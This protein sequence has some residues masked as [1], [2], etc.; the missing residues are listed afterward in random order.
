MKQITIP[1]VVA[2]VIIASL[3]CGVGK[4]Q[5]EPQPAPDTVEQKSIEQKSI[6]QKTE[7]Q[8]VPKVEI[9]VQYSHLNFFDRPLTLFDYPKRS[10]TLGGRIT[11]NLT[12]HFAAEA[13]ANYFPTEFANDGYLTGGRPFQAQ[14]GVK[15][16][17]RF[18]RFGLFIK[19]RPGFVSFGNTISLGPDRSV[20]FINGQ[21]IPI[22]GSFRERK[23]HFSFDLGGV[24]EVYASRRVF[25]RF[26]AG[27]TIIRY[28][29]HLEDNFGSLSSRTLDVPSRTEH[30][31]QLGVGVGFYLG[32][33]AG[34]DDVVAATPTRASEKPSA[35]TRFEAGAHFTSLTLTPIRQLSPF[36]TGIFGSQSTTAPGFG[37]RFTYNLTSYLAVEAETN[38]LPRRTL[39]ALGATG[40]IT[41]GQFGIKAGHRFERFGFFGKARPGFVTY[42][43]SLKQIGTAPFSLGD[44]HFLTGVFEVGRRTFFSA[45]VGG[46]FEVYPSRRWLL[47][48]DAGDTIIHYGKRS[49]FFSSVN[50]P[51][52]LTVVPPETKHNFQ[53]STGVAFRF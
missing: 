7:A 26:D 28:G 6:E 13:E 12:D 23:T 24:V 40:R 46:V 51:L 21:A 53:F 15:A 19:A 5:D 34:D 9:G 35:A 42:G 18:R 10:H 31:L 3:L 47:R 36:P 41:Q 38:L 1:H 4:A 39:L 2:A 44:I 33:P 20:I 30:N 22:V 49:G 32:K 14:F 52:P 11:Y 37:G 16:G 17:K 43:S 50:F 27:D 29:R 45:D 8:S 25:A 48:F